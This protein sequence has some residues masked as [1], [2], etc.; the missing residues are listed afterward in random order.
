MIFSRHI[1][2]SLK[3]FYS[4]TNKIDERYNCESEVNIEARYIKIKCFGKVYLDTVLNHVKNI[5]KNNYKSSCIDY[6]RN[7]ITIYFSN[8]IV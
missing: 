8:M 7:T 1:H 5:F 4:I 6:V 2:S 3:Y